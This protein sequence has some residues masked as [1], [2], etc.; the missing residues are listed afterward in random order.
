MNWDKNIPSYNKKNNT[1]NSILNTIN[2]FNLFCD[3]I[4]L[5]GISMSWWLA[6]KG[7]I[8]LPQQETN[9]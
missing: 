3:A 6:L 5:H 2:L 8:T 4:N 1:L 7:L 9:F